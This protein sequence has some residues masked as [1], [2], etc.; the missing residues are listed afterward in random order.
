MHVVFV[1][2][3]TKGEVSDLLFYVVAF[4]T[5]PS[6]LTGRASGHT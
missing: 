1:L 5:L 3:W 4:F 2:L 6:S